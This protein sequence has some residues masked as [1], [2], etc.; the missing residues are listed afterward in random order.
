LGIAVEL[1]VINTELH[2][3]IRPTNPLSGTINR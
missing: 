3:L 1:V 2:I